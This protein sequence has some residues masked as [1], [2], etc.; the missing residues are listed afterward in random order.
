MSYIDDSEDV[1]YLKEKDDLILGNPFNKE[2]NYVHQ[3][4]VICYCRTN[5]DMHIKRIEVNLYNGEVK[6]ELIHETDEKNKNPS[7]R[8]QGISIKMRTEDKHDEFYF[9]I[10]QHKGQTITGIKK[11]DD[12]PM[13]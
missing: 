12:K 5:E 6:I 4:T 2:W 1:L 9:N 10:S 8:R 3:E 13:K 7:T 11:C